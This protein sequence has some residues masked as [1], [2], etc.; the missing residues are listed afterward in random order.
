MKDLNQE[1]KNMIEADVPDLWDRIEASLPDNSEVIKPSKTRIRK[2]YYMSGIAAAC[3]CAAIIIPLVTMQQRAAKSGNTAVAEAYEEA[4]VEENAKEAAPAA[5]KSFDEGTMNAAMEYEAEEASEETA[6]AAAAPEAVH[7][8]AAPA[9]A[10]TEAAAMPAAAAAEE[11]EMPA[12]EPDKEET[13]VSTSEA[14]EKAVLLT[15]EEI[16]RAEAVAE[17]VRNAAAR[18]FRHLNGN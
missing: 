10:M 2:F 16:A 5:G 8:D 14:E 11:A 18:I 9:E 1:Y 6:P 17:R 15:P 3:I 13:A 7:E 12:D 4:F